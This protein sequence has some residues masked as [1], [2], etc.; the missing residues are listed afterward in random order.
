MT[1]QEMLR[2][3]NT[4]TTPDYVTWHAERIVS[5]VECLLSQVA[6]HGLKTLDLGHDTRV[7]LL[8]AKAGAD[9]VGNIAPQV[10]SDGSSALDMARFELDDGEVCQWA[11]NEFDFEGRF[12]YPDGTFDLV[13]AFEVIEP[14]RQP[15]ALHT[16]DQARP[17]AGRPSVHR[18]AE[19][20]RVGQDNAAV[21]P[22]RHLRL[23]AL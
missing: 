6:L 10:H 23:Q 16:G 4:G 12:P 20:K 11:L 1:R 15:P 19:Y 2:L 14:C 8:V 21:P 7:G 13:T 18:H 22:F 3:L 17:Q 9:L 5:S